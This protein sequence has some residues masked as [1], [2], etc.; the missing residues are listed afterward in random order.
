MKDRKVQLSIINLFYFVQP[1][2]H[3]LLTDVKMVGSVINRVVVSV[4]KDMMDSFA[5]KV[6]RIFFFSIK[7]KEP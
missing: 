5:K 2:T 6:F 4:L 3:V 1:L 7:L